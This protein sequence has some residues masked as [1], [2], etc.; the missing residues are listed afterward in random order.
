MKSIA[1]DYY[2]NVTIE[3]ITPYVN[4][5]GINSRKRKVSDKDKRDEIFRTT[6]FKP[7]F[8]KFLLR[9]YSSK[10]L[11]PYLIARDSEKEKNEENVKALNYKV[12]VQIEKNNKINYEERVALSALKTSGDN[13][14]ARKEGTLFKISF[15]SF[16]KGLIEILKKNLPEFLATTNFGKRKNKAYGSFY[17]NNTD[18][19]YKDIDD[20][21]ELKKFKFFKNGKNYLELILGKDKELLKALSNIEIQAIN[22]EK[23]GIVKP[24]IICRMNEKRKESLAIMKVLKKGDSYRL[25]V[26]PN[27]ELIEAIKNNFM[28]V[29]VTNKSFESFDCKFF[30]EYIG[31]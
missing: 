19:L 20:I 9:K 28:S 27:F 14:F 7:R 16:E 11:Q 6:E 17:I 24:S 13:Y 23:K 18:P 10:S 4:D 30:R 3:Q 25:Y 15:F 12:S 22:R 5:I 2:F 29:E 8:D 26:V 1:I 21:E 31:L